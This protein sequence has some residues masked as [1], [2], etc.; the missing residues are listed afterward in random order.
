ME[1]EETKTAEP[2]LSQP[3][4]TRHTVTEYSCGCTTTLI[5]GGRGVGLNA[6]A[7]S[8]HGGAPVRRV[9]TVM[10]TIRDQGGY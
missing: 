7:C 1:T 4:L 8:G 2:G 9:E 5:E 10:V 3:R 6:P